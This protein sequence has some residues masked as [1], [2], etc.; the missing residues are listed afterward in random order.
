MLRLPER[1]T[2]EVEA[3][4]IPEASLLMQSLSLLSVE[5]LMRAR[6]STP[7]DS[8]VVSLISQVATMPAPQRGEEWY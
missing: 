5:M 7:Y 8:P 2:A 4:P 6:P 3:T 1:T